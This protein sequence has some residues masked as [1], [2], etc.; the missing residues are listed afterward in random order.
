MMARPPSFC[1]RYGQGRKEPGLACR[2]VIE[3]TPLTG[4]EW[5]YNPP[6]YIYGRRI[7]DIPS[8]MVGATP[9]FVYP[10]AER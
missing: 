6:A 4:K 10:G 9:G 3:S 2:K 8:G 1:S 7:P 5:V